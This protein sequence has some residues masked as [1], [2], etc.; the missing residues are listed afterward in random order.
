MRK[1][2]LLILLLSGGLIADVSAEPRPRA[3]AA[4][5]AV[6]ARKA[7][8]EIRFIDISSWEIVD[9]Q[10]DLL[11][12]DV[13]RTNATGQ[14]AIL[15][16]DRTQVRLGRNSSL[17]VRQ[18]SAGSDAVL[19]LQSGTIWARAERGGPGVTVQTPAATAAIRGT[20]WTMTV[21]GER[22]TLTVLEGRVQLSNPQGSLE[23]VE[24]E[25]AVA[26][27]GQA[28][29][30]IVIVESD[31]R[32]QMLFYL[33]PREAFER[34]PPSAL[35][36][37]QMRQQVEQ[38]GRI[39]EAQRTADHWVSL[40]EAAL[41]LEG[42][43][44]ANEALAA[45]KRQRLSGSLGCRVMLVEAV[46]AASEGHYGEAASLFERAAPCLDPQRRAIALYGGYYARALAHPERV[47]PLPPHIG[48][49][50]A[51][52]L[53]AYAIG[54]LQDLPSAIEVLKQAEAKF[55]NDP[56]LPAYRAWLALLLNDR[57]QAEEAMGRSLSLD[58]NE[59]TALEVRAHFRSGFQ[60][61]LE[62]AL[63]DLQMAASITPGSSTTW[64]EI[65]NV[66]SA[67]GANREAEAAFQ[68][69]ISLDPQDPVSHANLAIFYLDNSRVREAKEHIDLA[70]AADP[71]FDVGLVARGRYHLQTGELD[72]AV[73]DLL[74]GTVSNPA[75]SQGQLLLAAAH[76]EKGDRVPAEQA[77]DNAQR[78][79]GN[80]PVIYSFRA[81]AAIDDYDSVTAI[82]NAQEFVRRSR[83]RG[84]DFASLGANHDAGSTLNNAFRL[85]G[86]NAWGEYYGD[87][88]FD[89]FV[90][91]SYI[92]QSLRGSADPFANEESFGGDVANNI[93]N[94]EA[95]SSLLQGL[96][97]EPHLISGRSRS[98]NLLRRPFF[99]GAIGGGFVYGGE[100]TGYVG[101]GEAQGYTN[102]PMPI[103]VYGNL[104]WSKVA[105]ERD[106]GVLSDLNSEL[107]ILG[108]NGYVTASP[109]L[110]DR[111][112]LYANHGENDLA[113]DFQVEANFVPFVDPTDPAVLP[114]P[115]RI[116]QEIHSQATN[117]GIG[118]SHT[119]G[120]RNVL[121]AAFLYSGVRREDENH[122][123][124]D[125]FGLPLP[126]AETRNVFKENT[127]LAAVN[128]AV[129]HGDL[130]WRY[131][132]EGGWVDAYQSQ[133]YTNFL[134]PALSTSPETAEDT[135][136][137]GRVYV[138]V[139]HD[140]SANFRAEYALFGSYIDSETNDISR[141][142]PRVGLAWSPAEGHWLRGGFMRSSLDLNTPT[143]SPI[144]ILG[145]QPNQVSV[146]TTGY[147]DTYA[148]R[149]DA[150]WTPDFFT[151]VEYQHQDVDD[152]QIPV[153][154]ASIP[155]TT[156]EGH[157]DRASLTGNLLLGHGFGLSSTVAFTGS[158]DQDAGSST[159]DEAL[160]F[161]PQWSGQVALTWVNQ[162]NVRATLAANYVG[163]RNN[164]SGIDLDDYWTVDAALTWEPVDKRFSIDL[165]AFNL[166]E[167]EIELNAGVPG[168]GRS[169]KGTVKVR[170]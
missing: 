103:S 153:P 86:M 101:E 157:I 40:A 148:L 88:V 52:F 156:S 141:L 31:D 170:F 167:E 112:V 158:E 34:M 24:G 166:L 125:F 63:S 67:R 19:E 58:P 162:A 15:F 27:I 32:E 44:K 65:G 13:L 147:V 23:L 46:I 33:P 90:G 48:G 94:G 107:E 164:E 127:Y 121:N 50:D 68:K 53:R 155:F 29:R 80:D 114:L 123:E 43:G 102:L 38:I 78:L 18:V 69:A 160:P 131:G 3:S 120:Y 122:F 87:A 105:D 84:G 55:P 83:D 150:E 75:Y 77:L 169:V 25:A 59:P 149:W 21:E 22:T 163:H 135:S 134:N 1:L 20:D 106:I 168:W 129:G 61:D 130:T 143:L 17:L 5:G 137:V 165:A 117:A 89:P 45:A 93:P 14:L 9:L 145:L 126:T 152:L 100:E 97:L 37:A 6:I 95:F 151:A 49:S 11:S 16:S 70:L 30:K 99:E 139:L 71:T 146:A 79:D 51:A 133:S 56:E 109:T 136:T 154:L 72:K 132:I 74:A 144:G 2:T 110:Y 35:P 41:S 119:F 142:E 108:G 54:F 118:W 36:V 64:N 113:R 62:G 7:G 28:P 116:E 81:A 140:I 111:V 60:G 66:Q 10:Q 42:R 138:D 96:M 57:A 73:D 104:Q 12:G 124:F 91:T 161:V 98:A 128:H 159:Y 47:E 8:E 4:A 115:L 85:Q 82:R 26:S 92:D 76:Y 39:P